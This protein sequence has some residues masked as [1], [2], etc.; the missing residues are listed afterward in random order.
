MSEPRGI[1][2]SIGVAEL[3]IFRYGRRFRSLPSAPCDARELAR[4]AETRGFVARTLI[5]D[6]ATTEDARAAICVAARELRDDDSFVLSFSGHGLASAM[7]E[8]FQQSWY[9]FDGPL[10]RFGFDGLDAL[11]ATF[12]AGVQITIVANC[13][14]AARGAEPAVETPP[15]RADVVRIAACGAAEITLASPDAERPSEF[16]RRVL[17]ELESGGDF[18]GFEVERQIGNCNS[19]SSPSSPTF[20]ASYNRA[21][22]S[23]SN[24]AIVLAEPDVASPVV[25]D[26]VTT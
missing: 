3:C 14:G 25:T 9:L 12:E 8:G 7:P 6:E 5:D 18:G 16:V 22:H 2:L 26:A 1:W 20:F 17:D 19:R 15:I 11:L 21:S 13:C 24:V 23:A 10:P 4:A